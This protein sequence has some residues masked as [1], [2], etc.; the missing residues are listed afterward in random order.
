MVFHSYIPVFWYISQN[1]GDQLNHFLVKELSG[2]PIVYSNRERPHYICVG[3]II[4]ECT[5][6]SII[7][8]AGFS[9]GHVQPFNEGAQVIAVRGTLSAKRINR[10][11]ALGDPALLL[12]RL[13]KPVILKKHKYG[14]IPHWNDYEYCLN[15]FSQYHI[16]D[17]FQP[18]KEFVD[19][20]VSCEVILSSGLHGLI[21]ADAYGV[22]NSWITF[23]SFKNL[24]RFKFNDYYSTTN[25]ENMGALNEINFNECV[26]H[27]FVY[28][29]LVLL[30][31]CPF[32]KPDYG[33][34][35][36]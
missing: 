6:N 9:Y 20:V 29:E 16:I 12:P 30:K 33:I 13:Y 2:K 19:D 28:S 25:Y 26:V 22:P 1:F 36:R 8:G 21:A 4:S 35:Q 24:D 11:C 27:G 10:E 31:S 14:I 32:L 15:K 7:W 34:D 3:S 23:D 18:I 5:E 17:P